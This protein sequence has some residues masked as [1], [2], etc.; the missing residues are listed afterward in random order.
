MAVAATHTYTN[1]AIQPSRN[2]ETAKTTT[3]RLSVGS[4]GKGTVLAQSSGI[5]AVNAVHTL[6]FGGSPSGGSFRLLYTSGDQSLL[7]GAIT[8]SGTA[9]TMVANIQA[10]LD[11]LFGTGVVTVAGSGPY[12]V[13]FGGRA[14]G[15][16]IPIPTVISSLTGTTPTLTP[17]YTTV[18]VSAGGTYY[19]AG[20]KNVAAVWTLT[21][22]AS[23]TTGT[24]KLA[25]T[26]PDGRGRL[27]T[28]N[29]SFSATA[30]TMASNITTALEALANIGS[31]N[32]TV[33]ST[34]TTGVSVITFAASLG[35]VWLEVTESAMLATSTFTGDPALVQTTAG[36]NDTARVVLQYDTVVTVYGEHTSGGGENGTSP[37][38]MAPA[39]TAGVF[40]TNEL[41]ITGGATIDRITAAQ[42]GR[43]IAGGPTLLSNAATEIT[44]F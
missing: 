29:I 12:T 1:T 40:R 38:T 33:S 10:A 36:V 13:T 34:V 44:L 30:A 2:P 22:I 19:P 16:D 26:V 8:Y 17:T 39:Y 24:F 35:N 14:A 28:A 20:D 18:G 32:V 43:Y 4:H 9:A 5:T 21:P 25:A 42:L 23:T 27:Q 15:L 31:G 41:K 7:S 37:R 6:T 3:V 11:A